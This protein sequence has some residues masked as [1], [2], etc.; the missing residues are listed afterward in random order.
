MI[1][2]KAKTDFKTPFL[3]T[4]ILIGCLTL[5][6]CV[7][8]PDYQKTS[9]FTP[10]GWS[11]GAK[12]MPPKPVTL[13]DWWQRLND[14]TL[15]SLITSAIQYNNDVASAKARVR[16]ARASV[17]QT[18]GAL[19]P[20]LDGSA[21]GNRSRSGGHEGSQY[22]GGFDASWEID[23]F[24]ANRRA[25][26]ASRYSLQAANE[27]LRATMVTLIGDI[28]QNYVEARG[29]QQKIALARSSAFTQ[30]KTA[31]LTREKFNAGAVSQLDLSNA[32]GQASST[33]ANI[34][35]MEANLATTIH[36]LSV[37]TGQTPAA[38]NSLFKTTKRIPQVKWPIPVGIPADILLT[39]PDL[40]A[41][42][43]R[44]AQSTARI[45]QQ[46][47]N[48]YPSLTL[49]GAIST[50]ATQI[51]ELGKSSSISWS[52]GPGISIPIFNAGQRA[53]AVE[54]ARAQR[55]QAFIA[56]RAGVLSALEEVENALV[57]LK[58]ERVR[59]GKLAQSAASY[60]K[61]L[62][63]S[64]ALYQ[65]GNTSFLELL[66]AERS[67]YSADQSSIDSRV[68]IV[69]DYIALMKALG[70]GWDGEVDIK[71]PE[72]QDGYIGPHIRKAEQP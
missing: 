43:R 30:R 62:E 1:T 58:K 36:R 72:V 52:G 13:A 9:L 47:A 45:G 37:L 11:Q 49:T 5:S 7:V 6:G 51:G 31:N 67:S 63:L 71:T 35:Q 17:W 29:L 66:T 64:R 69:N 39:R 34:P 38:L 33:E 60:R 56:Y 32:E 18:T 61:A 24:G 20:S 15:D 42:E 3:C 65:S 14:S 16:E 10:S 2:Q 54:I 12:E 40:R 48:R 26:E 23:I 41:L 46:E 27:D 55:D 25:L 21:S 44:Y 19:F 59:S 4:T 68:S 50:S 8:G 57:M 28:A 70:G 53:A 22:R